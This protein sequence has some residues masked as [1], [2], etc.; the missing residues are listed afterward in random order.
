MPPH[1]LLTASSH[2]LAASSRL[3]NTSSRLLNASSKP[4]HL[5]TFASS[6]QKC[7]LRES[8]T[9]TYVSIMCHQLCQVGVLQGAK[10]GNP[11]LR[12]EGRKQ[13]SNPSKN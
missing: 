12:K 11:F 3:L 13:V 5:L 6:R 8:V 9:H 2:L 1:Y 10:Q 7:H 4:P